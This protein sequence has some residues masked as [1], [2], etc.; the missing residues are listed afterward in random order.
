MSEEFLIHG[1][2]RLIPIPEI[3]IGKRIYDSLKEAGPEEVA[4]IDVKTE[5]FLTHNDFLKLTCRL[6]RALQNCGY[7][8]NDV[9]SISGENNNYFFVPVVAGFYL[10]MISA[11]LNHNYTERELLHSAGIAKPKIIFCSKTKLKTY[12]DLQRKVDYIERIIIMD[13]MDKTSGFDT[14]EDFIEKHCEKNFKED[15]LKITE[16]NIFE[17]LACILYS[18]GTTGFPK[19]VMTTHDNIAMRMS[20]FRD[21]RIHAAGPETIMGCL[22]FFH[23]YGFMTN[24]TGLAKKNK[25]VVM[26]R[27]E[28]AK[29]LK[30]IEKFKINNIS[31]V[32]PIMN[33]LVKNPMVDNYDLTSLHEI[34]CGAAPLSHELEQAAGKKFSYVSNLRQGYGLTEATLAITMMPSNERRSGSSGKVV[35]EMTVKICDPETRKSLGPNQIGEICVKGRMV[36]KGYYGDEKATKTCFTEDG[37]LLTGDLAYYDKDGY[38]YVVDRLKELIKYKAF[39]VAPAE[40]EAILIANP[41]IKDAGVVGKPDDEAGEVATA[42]IVKS[43][44]SLTEDEVKKVISDQLSKPKHL[45]GGVYFVN[46]I[47]K[48]P[49]GKILRR[50]LRDLLV[51]QKSK[52]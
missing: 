49:S 2:N 51:K 43:D 41:R 28:E 38:F 21:P 14:I 17:H 7:K 35:P 31:I 37:W 39:Q 9:I 3:S 19:G 27:F 11:P 25:I 18:S 13:P 50:Q 29:F 10:G 12:L 32:P 6:A 44:Q 20:H 8:S 4:Y 36:T 16:V 46:E 26:Q 48:N 47:P 23:G 42:F 34:T 40:L 33:F 22:P 15:D 45:H 30:A 1:P 5:R 52:L 24:V